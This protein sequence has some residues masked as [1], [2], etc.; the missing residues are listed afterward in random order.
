MSDKIIKIR[1]SWNRL[2]KTAQRN[3]Y[4][5]DPIPYVVDTIEKGN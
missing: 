2:D 1:E 5:K 3:Y 4:G